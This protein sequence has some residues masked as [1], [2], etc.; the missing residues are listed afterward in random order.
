MSLE[1]PPDNGTKM[2]KVP[3]ATFPPT[4]MVYS[5]N[6]PNSPPPPKIDT[7]PMSLIARVLTQPESKH[8]PQRLVICKQCKTGWGIRDAGQQ[9]H[10]DSGLGRPVLANMHTSPPTITPHY[11]PGVH[12]SPHPPTSHSHS[13]NSTDSSTSD[14]LM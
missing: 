8:R 13:F 7:V 14:H 4:A 6:K 1:G 2:I 3:M 12:R 9:C 11:P 5:I 10:L